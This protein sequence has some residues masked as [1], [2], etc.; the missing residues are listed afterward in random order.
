MEAFKDLLN[1]IHLKITWKYADSYTSPTSNN[2][3]SI[4]NQ[5]KDMELANNVVAENSPIHQDNTP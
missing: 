2:I 3:P 1:L 5:L 4:D